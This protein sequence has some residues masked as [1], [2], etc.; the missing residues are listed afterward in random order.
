MFRNKIKGLL[1][2]YPYFAS[3]ILLSVNVLKNLSPSFCKNRFTYKKIRSR[4]NFTDKKFVILGSGESV[5][6]LNDNDL[7]YIRNNVSIGIG[8]WI[9]HDFTPNIYFLEVSESPQLMKWLGDFIELINRKKNEY[10]DVLVI[11]DGANKSNKIKNFIFENIDESLTN[12]ILF[13]K[14]IIPP[15]GCIKYLHTTLKLFRFLKFFD[16]FNLTLHCRSSVVLCAILGLNLGFK[17]IDLVGVD[18]YSG[19]FK[20]WDD[21]NFHTDYGGLEKNKNHSLHSTSNPEFGLP[22]VPECFYLLNENF[23]TV[24]ILTKNTVLYPRLK[25]SSI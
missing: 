19:Y 15:T 10:R 20:S 6:E 21:K 22:T 13:S 16:F 25:I 7:D 8:R 23:I 2:N 1:S 9:Y 4:I 12:N 17:K 5:N 11:F 24:E 18:G 14:T 3:F